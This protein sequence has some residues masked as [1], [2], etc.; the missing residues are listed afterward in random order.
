MTASPLSTGEQGITKAGDSARGE[1]LGRSQEDTQ[2]RSR[3]AAGLGSAGRAV[4]IRRKA[5]G[6]SCMRRARKAR[7]WDGARPS[8]ETVVLDGRSQSQQNS[9]D[10]KGWN[11]LLKE[12]RCSRPGINFSLGLI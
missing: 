8:Q 6:F 11:G 5:W 10:L 4:C 9:L 2:S 12:M 3:V 7:P 1:D